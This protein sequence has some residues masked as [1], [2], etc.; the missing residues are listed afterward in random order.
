[1]LMPDWPQTSFFSNSTSSIKAENLRN[2][3]RLSMVGD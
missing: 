1:M 2:K 3:K